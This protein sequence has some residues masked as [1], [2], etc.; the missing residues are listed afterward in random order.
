MIIEILLLY[1]AYFAVLILASYYINLC[2]SK[3]Q[4]TKEE[5][6]D[7]LP[8]INRFRV[9]I[10]AKYTPFMLLVILAVSSIF[11]LI[12]PFLSDNWLLNSSIIFIV[13]YFT[14]PLA[15]KNFDNA[16]VTTGGNFSDT[17]INIFA[18]YYNVIIIGFGV[19]TA[20]AI[21]YNWGS[22]KAIHFLWFLIN[23]I[24]ISI[25]TGIAIKNSAE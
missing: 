10:T 20:T 9:T 17:A 19:G 8:Y 11:G 25:F 13:I 18:G 6:K 5:L 16:K 24:I 1:V 23:F 22:N 4:F 14:F 2:I 3:D 12:I 21:M 7:V 15:K